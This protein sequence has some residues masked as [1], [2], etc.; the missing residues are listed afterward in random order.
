MMPSY[1]GQKI[2]SEEWIEGALIPNAFFKRDTGEPC[3][4]IFDNSKMEYD[5]FVDIGEQLDDF[6]VNPQTL[7]ISFDGENFRSVEEVKQM[8]EHC[9]EVERG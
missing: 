7:Q 2:D 5:C 8:V 3:C 4:Y 6:E 9:I 1:K